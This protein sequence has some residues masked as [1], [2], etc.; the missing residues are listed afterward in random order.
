MIQKAVFF[1]G[2]EQE[3]EGAAK[4]LALHLEAG[5]NKLLSKEGSIYRT[6]LHGFSSTMNGQH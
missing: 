6:D 4:L 5:I 1:H 3:Q 2:T